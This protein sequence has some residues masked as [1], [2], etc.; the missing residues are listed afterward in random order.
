MNLT[1]KNRGGDASRTRYICYID[2]RRYHAPCTQTLIL[3]IIYILTEVAGGLEI[4]RARDRG[5]G[6][7]SVRGERVEF[8]IVVADGGVEVV[9]TH[10]D[11]NN[12]NTVEY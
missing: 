4:I 9:P 1:A 10:N 11:D 12:N 5:A 3:S 2:F 8:V 7:D 6:V